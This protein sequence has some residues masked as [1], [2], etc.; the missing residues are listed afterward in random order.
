MVGETRTIGLRPEE[1][2]KGAMRETPIDASSNFYTLYP[3]KE[4]KKVTSNIAW[5][6]YF[7]NLARLCALGFSGFSRR[8]VGVET[9]CSADESTG[10]FL[11]RQ[12]NGASWRFEH[13]NNNEREAIAHDWILL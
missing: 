4:S 13:W 6:G 11:G 8:E 5:R 12:H 7:H 3:N 9:L 1:Y 2:R 10:A